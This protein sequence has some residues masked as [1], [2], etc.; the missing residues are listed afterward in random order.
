V[1][2]RWYL[3]CG[4]SCRDVGEAAG[5]ARRHRRPPH[6]LPVGAAL[7]SRVHRGCPADPSCPGNRWSA[8][9]T[10]RKIAG[11]RAYRYRAVDQHGQVIDVL[12]PASR[13][14]PSSVK[15]SGPDLLWHCGNATVPQSRHPLRARQPEVPDLVGRGTRYQPGWPLL[16]DRPPGRGMNRSRGKRRRRTQARKGRHQGGVGGGSTVAV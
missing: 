5:R 16:F 15:P 12:L 9:G 4:L 1:A 8:D 13:D 10:P 11:R 7:R 3:R 2:V 6:H 14:L